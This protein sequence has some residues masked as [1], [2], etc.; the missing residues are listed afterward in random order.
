[1]TREK[2]PCRSDNQQCCFSRTS[3]RN[4]RG[5]RSRSPL[6]LTPS[7]R[8]RPWV[9][10]VSVPVPLGKNILKDV[11]WENARQR[12]LPS[13]RSRDV[14]ERQQH[15]SESSTGSRDPRKI[16]SG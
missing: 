6:A 4:P 8:H 2:G 10:G 16:K 14:R 5:E 9:K 3:A 1:M 11:L 7:L 13:D 15:G 12:N